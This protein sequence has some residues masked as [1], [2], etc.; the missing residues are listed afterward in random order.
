MGEQ[1]RVL[2]LEQARMDNGSFS[3]TSRPAPA[4]E[5]FSS[6]AT[7]ASSSTTGPRVVLT[8]NA[9]SASSVELRGADQVARLLAE[10]AM[11]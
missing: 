11:K 9:S 8:K 6:A 1:H 7:S 10:R 2:E 4:I 5:P 3:K